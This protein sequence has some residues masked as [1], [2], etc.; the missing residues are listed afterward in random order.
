[1]EETQPPEKQR[2]TGTRNAASPH[3]PP[4]PLTGQTYSEGNPE[5]N[6]SWEGGF[7]GAQKRVLGGVGLGS[8]SGQAA[9]RLSK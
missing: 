5:G 3:L 7:L 1:M 2:E 9:D 4:E 6:A 8:E